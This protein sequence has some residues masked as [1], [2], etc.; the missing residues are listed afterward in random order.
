MDR[1]FGS[2]LC[3]IGEKSPQI[4]KIMKKSIQSIIAL[5]FIVFCSY[6]CHAENNIHQP[7]SNLFVSDAGSKLFTSDFDLFLNSTNQVFAQDNLR[8]VSAPLVEL[9]REQ[10]EAIAWVD[11]AAGAASVEL[12]LGSFLVAGLASMAYYKDKQANEGWPIAYSGPSGDYPKPVGSSSAGEIHNAICA[13]FFDGN[14]PVANYSNMVLSANQVDPAITAG[15]DGSSETLVNSIVS[16]V[17]VTD[18]STVAKQKAFILS[19][20]P[21]NANDAESLETSLQTIHTCAESEIS[22][23]I[24]L[25]NTQINS[26]Q[27]NQ[28]EKVNL[29]NSFDILKHSMILWNL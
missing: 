16:S 12:G 2:I 3:L 14:Y 8:S 22:Q 15:L 9:T 29:A 21:L 20:F 18:F 5:L 25:L 6:N 17:L 11:L 19:E 7:K 1:I 4:F 23:E 27:L 28:T 24:D 13:A 10:K 26:Y